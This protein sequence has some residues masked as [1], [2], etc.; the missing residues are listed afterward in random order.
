ML[1]QA[2][3]FWA[4]RGSGSPASGQSRDRSPGGRRGRWGGRC[5]SGGAKRPFVFP[6]RSK[7][8]NRSATEE[9]HRSPSG[10]CAC[11]YRDARMV[12]C[13]AAC[14]ARLV[15]GERLAVFFPERL[16]PSCGVDQLVPAGKKRMAVG[17]HRHTHVGNSRA[18]M[19]RRPTGTRDIRFDRHWMLRDLH[20]S[21]TGGCLF[22]LSCVLCRR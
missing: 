20:R 10:L 18:G 11:G 5:R 2:L 6:I 22:R 13:R 19:H 1:F 8:A 12:L 16:D 15:S 9:R 7:S 14:Q 4:A 21:S 3:V 17:T